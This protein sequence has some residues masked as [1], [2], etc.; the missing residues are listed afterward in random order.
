[1][2][3]WLTLFCGKI[4]GSTAHLNDLA[5]NQGLIMWNRKEGLKEGSK[6]EETKWNHE[7]ILKSNDEVWKINGRGTKDVGR[8]DGKIKRLKRWERTGWMKKEGRG[9]AGS[10]VVVIEIQVIWNTYLKYM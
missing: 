9:N 7:V 2:C 5:L 10:S 6:E 4:G 3:R 1:M 8:Y